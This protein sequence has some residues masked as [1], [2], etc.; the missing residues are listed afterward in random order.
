M[1]F[2]DKETQYDDTGALDECDRAAVL[3]SV[4]GGDDLDAG[5]Y[6]MIGSTGRFFEG[7]YVGTADA[8]AVIL[9]RCNSVDE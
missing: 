6:Y 9:Y 7:S 4:Y 2:I 3:V 8:G 5:L 1:I